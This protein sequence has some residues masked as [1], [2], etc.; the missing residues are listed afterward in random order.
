LTDIESLVEDYIGHDDL[1]HRL[2]TISENAVRVRETI[3]DLVQPKPGVICSRSTPNRRRD[4][5]LEGRRILLADD[6]DVIRETIRDVLTG[7]GC[8]VD[9]ASDGA[10]AMELIRHKSFDLVLSDIKMPVRSGYEVF[11]A[12]KA[13]N[14]ATPVILTTG[15]G[16]DPNHSIV[17]AR[18]EG[19]SAVLFKPF[20][21]DQLLLEIRSA[22]K[23]AQA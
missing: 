3:K 6:E 4:P 9:T 8:E 19:L 2:R 16:Y 21:V 18:R 7:Y 15:F 13:A 17:R 23:G 22:L 11:A 14:P 1:R 12:A 10:A 5:L 20:K